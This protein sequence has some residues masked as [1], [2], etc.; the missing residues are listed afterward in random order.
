MAAATFDWVAYRAKLKEVKA[1]V[2]AAIALNKELDSLLDTPTSFN[3][4][5]H[6]A[7]GAS[8]SHL[9]DAAAFL[10]EMKTK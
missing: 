5:A 7:C 9:E 2:Q 10:A 1:A 8:F 3:G 4:P 6:L